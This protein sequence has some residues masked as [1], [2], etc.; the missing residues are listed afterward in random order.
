MNTDEAPELIEYPQIADPKR[1]H[2]RAW[3]IVIASAMAAGLIVAEAFVVPPLLSAVNQAACNTAQAKAQAEVPPAPVGDETTASE[4][5]TLPRSWRRLRP[6]TRQRKRQPHRPSETIS[7]RTG[8]L[9]ARQA[10]VR[11][12]ATAQVQPCASRTSVFT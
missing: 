10:A 1:S 8:S 6:H 5:Q 12:L 4:Q 7:A 11:M 2:R 9:Y 3:E